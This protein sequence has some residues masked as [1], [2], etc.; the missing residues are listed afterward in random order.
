LPH[1]FANLMIGEVDLLLVTVGTWG[2]L[3]IAR[4]LRL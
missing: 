3:L 2:F 1:P 4:L